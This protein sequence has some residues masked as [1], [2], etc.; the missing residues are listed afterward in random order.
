MRGTSSATKTFYKDFK[1]IASLLKDKDVTFGFLNV[2][3][4]EVG[5]QQVSR[6]PELLLFRK[7]DKT[8][9]IRLEVTHIFD[10]LRNFI[11][12]HLGDSYADPDEL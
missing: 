3:K 12:K 5:L 11:R 1:Q 2:N 4:N 9:P 10:H 7:E 8:S 6:L